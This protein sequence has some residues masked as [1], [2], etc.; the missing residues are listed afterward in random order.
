MSTITTPHK[1]Y[2]RFAMMLHSRERVNSRTTRA[3]LSTS[4]LVQRRLADDNPP[5][6]GLL[7]SELGKSAFNLYCRKVRKLTAVTLHDN[8]VTPFTTDITQSPNTCT[9]T[10]KK[11][12]IENITSEGLAPKRGRIES[13]ESEDHEGHHPYVASDQSLA[14]G[15]LSNLLSFS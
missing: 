7:R 10:S 14:S 9:A 11:R 4:S 8:C 15:A 6:G 12:S 3:K 2:G 1:F 13:A 5:T